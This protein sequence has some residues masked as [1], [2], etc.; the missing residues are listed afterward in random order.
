MKAMLGMKKIVSRG[1]RAGGRRG[2]VDPAQIWSRRRRM[3]GSRHAPRG[4]PRCS[5]GP[6]G[7]RGSAAR[8]QRHGGVPCELPVAAPLNARRSPGHGE[9][10]RNHFG[11]DRPCVGRPSPSRGC[12]GAE[13]EPRRRPDGSREQSLLRRACSH[14]DPCLAERSKCSPERLRQPARR[15]TTGALSLPTHSSAATVQRRLR[16]QAPARKPRRAA[17]LARPRTI[18]APVAAKHAIAP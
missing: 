15:P 2:L 14:V 6:R 9:G 16:S 18:S 8:P 12:R 17:A 1:A 4:P 3:S 7:P 5:T 10:E 11:A 13:L